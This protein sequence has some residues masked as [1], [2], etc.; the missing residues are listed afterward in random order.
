M[1]L[2]GFTT[3]TEFSDKIPQ[4]TLGKPDAAKNML[5]MERFGFTRCSIT[6]IDIKLGEVSI[7]DD[8]PLEW[9]SKASTLEE[10]IIEACAKRKLFE[11]QKDFWGRPGNPCHHNSCVRHIED[12]PFGQ[13]W[14]WI[15]LNPNYNG[16]CDHV[17]RFDVMPEI[18]VW[19]D[20]AYENV[21]CVIAFM[22]VWRVLNFD[23]MFG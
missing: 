17:R 20:E 22:G 21:L 23:P 8:G 1:I 11:M 6:K 5:D 18:N 3:R 13:K 16:G 9:G 7:F 10:K 2:I 12:I 15:S 4:T 19:G 14:A